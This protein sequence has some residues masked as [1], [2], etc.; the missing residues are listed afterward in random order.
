MLENCCSIMTLI[1]SERQSICAERG[2]VHPPIQLHS[3][4]TP[5]ATRSPR[6]SQD[7]LKLAKKTFSSSYTMPPQRNRSIACSNQSGPAL[8]CS[9][10]GA[11]AR[12]WAV[13]R[14]LMLTRSLS[15]GD[16]S[17]DCSTSARASWWFSRETMAGVKRAM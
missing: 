4:R 12:A 1:M 15:T 10:S 17:R 13:Q 11:L 3:R 7:D 6:N 8:A 5:A 9:V 14:L 2:T 16:P